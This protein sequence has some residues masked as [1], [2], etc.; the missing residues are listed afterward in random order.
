MFKFKPKQY[1]PTK[2]HRKSKVSFVYITQCNST[3]AGETEV[4]Y[5]NISILLKTMAH[6]E[7]GKCISYQYTIQIKNQTHRT[8]HTYNILIIHINSQNNVEI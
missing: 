4:H 2:G 6:S 1:N 5:T 8:Q 3:T 7:N